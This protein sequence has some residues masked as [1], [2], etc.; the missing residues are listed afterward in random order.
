MPVTSTRLSVSGRFSERELDDVYD[1]LDDPR[2]REG[3]R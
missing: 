3:E 2:E 1:E